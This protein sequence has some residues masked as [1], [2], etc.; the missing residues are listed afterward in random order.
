[1]YLI[2]DLHR[3]RDLIDDPIRILPQNGSQ[4][5]HGSG[6][7]YL[8]FWWMVWLLVDMIA[9]Y[10]GMKNSMTVQYLITLGNSNNIIVREYQLYLITLVNTETKIDKVN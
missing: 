6:S 2:V 9:L 5:C 8:Y 4:I 10:Q 3:R 1:M 7:E